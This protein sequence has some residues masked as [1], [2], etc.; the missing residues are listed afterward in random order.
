MAAA[1]AGAGRGGVSLCLATAGGVKALT[2]SAFTLVW[3]HSIAKVEW[4]EDWRLTPSGLELVQARVK[5]TGPGMEPPAEARL[6]D[7]WFQWRPQRAP[8]P[9]LVLGNSGAAG[10]WRLCHDGTCW[11]LSEIVGHPIGANVT[12]LSVCKEP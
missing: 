6:V 11:T 8:M 10:E 3:T 9:E 7:G 12:T 1:S 2:L 5:G 4:Q